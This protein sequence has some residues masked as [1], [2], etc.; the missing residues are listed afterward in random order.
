MILVLAT[1]SLELVM[2][3]LKE[4]GAQKTPMGPTLLFAASL[5]DFLSSLAIT[6]FAM[7]S[8][9]GL[10]CRLA[11]PLLPFVAFVLPLWLGRLWIWWNPERAG[12]LL[13]NEDP[14][15]MGVRVA[16]ALLFLF[17][18]GHDGSKR[19]GSMVFHA[20]SPYHEL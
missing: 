10:T 14:M 6:F 19:R 16:L 9:F 13:S 12:K 8:Q 4:V 3:A 11:S 2:P 1:T 17:V 20:F 5:A 15:E 18:A 7:W